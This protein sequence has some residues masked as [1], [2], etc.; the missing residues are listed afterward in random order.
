[1][2]QTRTQR[3]ERYIQNLRKVR[4]LSKPQFAPETDPDIL[5]E[6]IQGNAVRSFELMGENNAI[7]AEGIYDRDPEALTDADIAE[8]EAFAGKLFNFANSEDVGVAYKIHELLLKTARFRKD[9]AMIIKELYYTGI[10]LHYMNVRDG[11]HDVNVLGSRI[12][13]VFQEGAHYIEKYE[14]LDVESR[15]YIIR[16]VGNI[17]L[18]V[19]RRTREDC[20]RY[21]ELFDQAMG[22][23]ESPY[24]HEL[25]PEIPWDRFIYTMHMDQMT[26]LAYLREV[27]KPDME[28]ANRVLE[29]ATYVYEHEKANQGEESRLQNWRVN[30]YYHAARYHAGKGTARE[31]VEDLMDMIDQA[32]ELDYSSNGINRNL[33]GAA[34]L[35]S[36]EPRLTEQDR[37]ELADRLVQKREAAHRYLNEMPGNEYP[38]VASFAIRELITVESDAKSIDTHG[39]M[40]SILS[41][42]KPT[43]VHSTMV[44]HLTKALIGRTVDTNPEALVGLCGIQT[45]EEIRVQKPRLLQIAYDCGLYHDVG[46][47]A[48]IHYIDTN[49]R[50]LIDEE[51][52]CIQSHPAIGYGLLCD[53]GYKEYLAPAALYHHCFY[54]GKGGYPK[55]VPPCPPEIKGIVDALSVADS[56]D[57]AT[58]NIGRCY[59]MAKPF[60]T[61]VGEFRAQSGTRYAPYIANLFDDADFCTELAQKLD[62]ERKAVYL[63]VYH[64]VK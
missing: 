61:L 50:R 42:H 37:A 49:S 28:I 41:G 59:N 51:F 56:L 63:Q 19:S 8:L 11:D 20:Q 21:L 6:E 3:F 34:Y 14:Q 17:R 2:E 52:T 58:D 7:L 25:N 31:V 46:K 4:A 38:R 57:A 26:L 29:S 24:Y 40:G 60:Q 55:D 27:E 47:S 22:I 35:F 1:M 15:K 62:D 36:Y 33:M 53:A 44:A 39:I 54:N 18:P 16:C 32:D 48:V 12:Y 5:L 23:I 10:C 9:D 43:F 13:A 30:Y 45:A 64:V